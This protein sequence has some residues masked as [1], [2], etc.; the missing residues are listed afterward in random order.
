MAKKKSKEGTGGSSTA[1]RVASARSA[2]MQGAAILE[3]DVDDKE[4]GEKLAS[5]AEFSEETAAT[6]CNTEIRL[7]EFVLM[8]VELLNH[9]KENGTKGSQSCGQQL[10]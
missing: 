8:K 5:R 2:L 6:I 4:V 9:L 3:S 10:H 1:N 7:S